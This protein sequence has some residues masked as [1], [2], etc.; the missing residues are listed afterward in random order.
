MLK[1]ECQ[2]LL[3]CLALLDGG[4]SRANRLRH[5]PV[6]PGA[7]TSVLLACLLGC[8]RNCA[9]RHWEQPRGGLPLLPPL[10]MPGLLRSTSTSKVMNK[11]VRCW[12]LLV[13]GYRDVGGAVLS[14]VSS[15]TNWSDPAW[16]MSGLLEDELVT[17]I[18][19]SSRSGLAT[20]PCAPV[21]FCS[22][23]TSA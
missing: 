1:Q 19:F 12:F 6:V 4:P 10:S 18:G 17:L 20:E 9:C 3:P 21:L 16:L 2:A 8:R 22:R 5:S 23:L 13:R 7:R 11:D 14:V 15:R